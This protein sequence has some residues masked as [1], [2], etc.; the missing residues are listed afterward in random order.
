MELALLGSAARRPFVPQLAETARRARSAPG[1]ISLLPKRH[2]IA[3][4]P[5]LHT[6]GI[7]PTSYYEA[8]NIVFD[9]GQEL[10]MIYLEEEK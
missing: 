9:P 2:E 10:E 3:K 1:D 7:I 6:T 4:M 5:E 8:I